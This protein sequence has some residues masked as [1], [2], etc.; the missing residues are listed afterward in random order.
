MQNM[1]TLGQMTGQAQEAQPQKSKID[2]SQGTTKEAD[3]EQ[4][5][6]MIIAKIT[7]ALESQG[8]YDLPENEGREGEIRQ[9]IEEIARAIVEND[10]ETL[11]ASPIYAF[12]T[13]KA[14]QM[15]AATGTPESAPMPT[16]EGM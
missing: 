4:D 13:Q 5:L 10:T 12:I 15:Q 1:P 11:K 8:Y 16:M 6:A 3:Q 9:E 7:A 2:I 14:G